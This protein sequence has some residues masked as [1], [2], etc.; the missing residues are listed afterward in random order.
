MIV[1]RE[2][3]Q[4]L[5]GQHRFDEH[6]FLVYPEW[7]ITTMT[8]VDRAFG[9]YLSLSQLSEMHDLCIM[10]SRIDTAMKRKEAAGRIL[11]LMEI[12]FERIGDLVS[13]LSDSEIEALVAVPNRPAL[14]IVTRILTRLFQAQRENN[15]EGLQE[16]LDEAAKLDTK[17]IVELVVVGM[18]E[19]AKHGRHLEQTARS[20]DAT[21]STCEEMAHVLNSLRTIM[22]N[23]TALAGSVGM[24]ARNVE[25]SISTRSMWTGGLGITGLAGFWFPPLFAL[26]A[27]AGIAGYGWNQ[28]SEEDT[29]IKRIQCAGGNIG[30]HS[31]SCRL[32]ILAIMCQVGQFYDQG[33]E[34]YSKYRELLRKNFRVDPEAED[35]RINDR[36][37]RLGLR[38]AKGI[39]ET[40][41]EV[42]VL[43]KS[44]EISM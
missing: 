3:S 1:L 17:V 44:Y 34:E 13:C 41:I 24:L 28:K 43:G 7:R 32:Y 2:L 33:T 4:K 15:S 30:T 18:S 37:K 20:L 5:A 31:A 12:F 25:G 10:R 26:W 40:S 23:N 19:L 39:E 27:F 11:T 9:S 6:Y 42:G 36:I 16:Y 29:I 14:T 38:I 35:M 21:D 22:A 8:P